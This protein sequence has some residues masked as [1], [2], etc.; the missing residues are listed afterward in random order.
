LCNNSSGLAT[1]Q[2]LLRIKGLHCRGIQQLL[3][4]DRPAANRG[5]GLGSVSIQSASFDLCVLQCVGKR[6]CG[7]CFVPVF[8]VSSILQRIKKLTQ[9][10]QIPTG[11]LFRIPHTSEHSHNQK[12]KNAMCPCCVPFSFFWLWTNNVEAALQS[13]IY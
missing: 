12:K 5:S 4:S 10:L 7:A 8:L 3:Y 6:C 1:I 2:F 11:L 13:G 9:N